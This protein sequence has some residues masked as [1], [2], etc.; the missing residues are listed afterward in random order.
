MGRAIHIPE[1]KKP[2]VV[3][4]LLVISKNS[5]SMQVRTVKRNFLAPQNFMTV[6]DF[7]LEDIPLCHKSPFL[8]AQQSES[9]SPVARQ[10]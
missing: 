3:S 6:H 10:F 4:M 1:R 8:Y 9:Q 5:L 2:H 7:F